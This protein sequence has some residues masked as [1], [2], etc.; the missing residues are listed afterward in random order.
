MRTT[1]LPRHHLIHEN[2]ISK[3]IIVSSFLELAEMGIKYAMK[4]MDTQLEAKHQTSS[5]YGAPNAQH[6]KQLLLAT[7]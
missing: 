3:N 4:A 6:A 7:H 5:A 1:T 2:I